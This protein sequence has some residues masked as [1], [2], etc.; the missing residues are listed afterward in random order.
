M[1]EMKPTC[2]HCTASLPP[3]A[4]DATICSY[5]CTFCRTCADDVLGGTC[6]N[7]GGPLV[8]RP[9]RAV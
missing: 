3:G 1:L 8:A 2:E 9:A 6:P 5:E 4:T 7:C